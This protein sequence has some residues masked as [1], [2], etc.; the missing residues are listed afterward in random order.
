MTMINSSALRPTLTIIKLLW[1]Y[2]I[3]AS[4]TTGTPGSV[5]QEPKSSQD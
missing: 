1:V 4:S 3:S 5:Q 2:L